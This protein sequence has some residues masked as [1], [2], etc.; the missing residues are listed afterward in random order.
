MPTA[1]PETRT[2]LTQPESKLKRLYKLVKPKKIRVK[3]KKGGAAVK[4]IWEF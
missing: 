1:N 3:T 2:S 4:L